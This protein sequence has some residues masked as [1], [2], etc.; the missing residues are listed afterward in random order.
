M[1]RVTYSQ[2]IGA[3]LTEL[4]AAH[5]A[6]TFP[7]PGTLAAARSMSARKQKT[8]EILAKI[9]GLSARVSALPTA[10]ADFESEQREVDREL[11]EIES[12]SMSL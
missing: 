7:Q 3:R 11:S 6:R 5:A 9:D 2:R 10:E 4:R 1:D 12:L 8:Q